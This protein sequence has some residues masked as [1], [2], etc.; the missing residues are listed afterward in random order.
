[1]QI[2]LARL[3]DRL[4]IDIPKAAEEKLAL[5]TRK[6]PAYQVRGGAAKGPGPEDR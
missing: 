1:M 6:Y 4:D 2:H 3:A 5:N